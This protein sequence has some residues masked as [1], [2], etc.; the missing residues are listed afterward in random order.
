MRDSVAL[1][2]T[3]LR[4]HQMTE[5][6]VAEARIRSV[7]VHGLMWTPDPKYSFA[8]T[9][10]RRPGRELLLTITA[11]DCCIQFAGATTTYSYESTLDHVEPG[12]YH[13]KVFYALSRAYAVSYDTARSRAR[14]VLDTSLVVR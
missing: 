10:E 1:R 2:V 3:E 5:L 9:L 8:A 4:E 7:R 6:S 11:T 13:L 12:P 14:L